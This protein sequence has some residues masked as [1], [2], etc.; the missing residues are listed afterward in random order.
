MVCKSLLKETQFYPY[1]KID[2]LFESKRKTVRIHQRLDQLE[3][4]DQII[5][6]ILR[7]MTDTTTRNYLLTYWEY[8]YQSYL[9]GHY[10]IAYDRYK[11]IYERSRE[12]NHPRMTAH[13]IGGMAFSLTYMGYFSSSLALMKEVETRT[14]ES[15][16]DFTLASIQELYT[17]TYLGLSRLKKA[18]KH[19]FK[20]LQIH[21]K[22]GKTKPINST[23]L[24]LQVEHNRQN[25]EKVHEIL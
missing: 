1:V 23:M 5:E 12:T 25:K 15:K 2:S 8:A 11:F 14:H 18:R 24:W 16:I 7:A 6:E 20:A 13:A 19:V 4:A 22:Q 17:L 3:K 9:Q 10:Q 21:K